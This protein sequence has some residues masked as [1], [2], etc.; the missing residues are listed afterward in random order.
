L[1]APRLSLAG[2]VAPHLERFLAASTQQRLVPP[3][4][5]PLYGAFLLA[6]AATQA[7][8]ANQRVAVGGSR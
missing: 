6:R 3:I 1:G 7:P 2:G 4:G 8:V 5:D